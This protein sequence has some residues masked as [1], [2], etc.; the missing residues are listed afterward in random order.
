LILSQRQTVEN[1][2]SDLGSFFWPKSIAIVGASEDPTTIRGRIL[3]FLLQRNYS[4]QIFLIS[5]TRKSILDRP[6]F[7]SVRDL[8]IPIDVVLIAVPADATQSILEDCVANRAKFSVLFN[9]G[10]ADRGEA[11]I[12]A[13]QQ[14]AD[15]ARSANLRI[16]GPNTAGFFNVQGMIPATFARSVDG[17]RSSAD[18]GRLEPG[19]VGIIAQSAG[20]GFG[21]QHRCA[22]QH[23]LG[24]SYIVSTGNEVDLEALDFLE[25]MIQDAHTR[26]VLLLIEGLKNGNRLPDVARQAAA[27]GKPIIAAKFGRTSAGSRAAISHAA[28][29]SGSDS[30]YSAMFRRSGVIRV[31]DEEEMSDLAAAFSRCPLPQGNR[32][33]IVT[34]SG[35]AGVWMAD[36]CE[37]IGLEVPLLDDSTRSALALYLPS[38]GSTA[39]PIDV[40]A[41]VTL[42]PVGG[43]E[44]SLF[45]RK[46]LAILSESP[47]VDAV[48]F[49]ANLSDGEIFL[50]ERSALTGPFVKPLLLYTHTLAPRSTLELIWCAGLVCFASTRRTARALKHLVD[51]GD[52]LRR[53]LAVESFSLPPLSLDQADR[54]SLAGGLCEYQAKAFLNRYSIPIP[55]EQIA[56]TAEE[57]VEIATQIGGPVALKIQSPDIPHKT[58]K[59]GVILALESKNQVSAAFRRLIENARRSQPHADIHGVLVQQMMPKAREM[60]LGIVR[61]RDFGPLLMVAMGGIHLEVHPDVVFEPLPVRRAS[62]LEM[63]RCLRGW[64]L[65]NGVRGAGRADLGAVTQLMESLSLLVESAGDTINEIDLNPVFVYDE[66]KGTVVVDA[67]IVGKAM[68]DKDV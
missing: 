54:D 14:I 8:P 35:G 5:T 3:K 47:A 64:P 68:R 53:R 59:G 7:N 41:Q 23:G 19:P 25:Y 22:V 21:Q 24:F 50:R 2:M 10:F 43:G 27:L 44:A 20:L 49:I 28:R 58:D 60:A 66:G 45:L 13:Q 9:S 11:G 29:L 17:D 63:L 39:N 42:N 46:I 4:G 6:T 62:A 33:A 12:A 16:C 48:I 31:E 38:F 61:D 65:L 26:V 37:A 32:V 18:L 40:T 57:A 51:Y 1:Q 55:R 15:L 67:V 36:A 56:R 34:T 30:A 52:F